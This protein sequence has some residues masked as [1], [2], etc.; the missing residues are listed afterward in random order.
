MFNTPET[1]GSL[2]RPLFCSYVGATDNLL[3]FALNNTKPGFMN[4]LDS[5][6]NI[7]YGTK[8]VG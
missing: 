1:T 7:S 6:Q 3:L 5:D 8:A 2:R 4:L